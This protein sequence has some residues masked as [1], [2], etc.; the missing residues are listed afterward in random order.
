MADQVDDKAEDAPVVDKAVSKAD[1]AK[2][3]VR[4]ALAAQPYRGTPGFADL[5]AATDAIIDALT[6]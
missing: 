6:A 4:E 1:A 3:K 5:L 2:A